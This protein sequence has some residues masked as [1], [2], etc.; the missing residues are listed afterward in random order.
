MWP[1]RPPRAAFL[2]L[3]FLVGSATAAPLDIQAV[4]DAQWPPARTVKGQIAPILVKAQVLLDRARFSPGEIDG[5]SGDNFRKALTA[6]AAGKG[7]NSAGELTEDVWR[8]LASTSSEPILTEYTIS[9]DDLRGP[10]VKKIPARLESMKKLP[11]LA[12][13]SAREKLAEKF[14]MSQELLRALNRGKKFEPAGDKIVVANVAGDDLPQKAGRIEVDKNSQVLK[15][16]GTDEK[17][18][19]VYPATV[20][21]AEKPAPSGRLK[22]TRVSKNPTY[23]YNP[24]YAFKAVRT[25]KPFTIKPGPNNPVGSVWIGLSGEGYGIHGTPDPS[26]IGKSES[27]G[28]VRL[29]N[30][31]ALRLAS[32]VAKGIPVDFSGGEP[33]AGEA[34]ADTTRKRTRR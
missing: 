2:I 12:Y 14:H 8:A 20:G 28:C 4:N 11:A 23:H 22:V 16:F 15:V 6:F 21:S 17:L 31:D 26:K 32:A 34:S 19:A 3:T 13:T 30:W 33:A 27:H 29:T 7:L 18:L 24:K 10:F 25:T 1:I 5:K 9:A